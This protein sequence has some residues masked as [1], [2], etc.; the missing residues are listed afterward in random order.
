MAKLFEADDYILVNVLLLFLLINF[1][2][3]IGTIY[4]LMALVDWMAYYIALDRRAFK[5]IPIENDK[6]KRWQ[7]LVWAM[8]TYVLFIF[9]IN[10]ITT[11]FAG[12]PLAANLSPFEHVSALIAGTF[13]ATPI[14]FG[15]T[16][17]KLLVW[18]LLIPIIETRFF[19]RTLLQW[20][21]KSSNVQEPT[22]K[23]L[24]TLRG[25]AVMAFFGALFSV[26]HI[27]AKGITNN[28]SLFVTFVFG[29]VSVGLVLYFREAV[30]AVFLHI[31]TNT[32]ATMQQLGIGFFDAAT[33]GFNQGGMIIMAGMLLTTWLLLFHEIPFIG[34]LKTGG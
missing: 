27:V 34:R 5:L 2:L 13:S 26:F 14:L 28:S 33:G 24:F 17:L 25:I 12:V 16:Y 11:R 7:N 8:G 21:L 30:Q 9:A 3:Q 22:A 23:A 31:I 32:I 18:G 15:S 1:N 19:F 29:V 4:G 6:S 20:G 10:Y